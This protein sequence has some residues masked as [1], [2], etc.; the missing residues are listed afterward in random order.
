MRNKNL[1]FLSHGLL[2]LYELTLQIIIQHT[3]GDKMLTIAGDGLDNDHSFCVNS[4]RA[5]GSPL[6]TNQF[7]ERQN[8]FQ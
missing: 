8:N 2:C 4:D 3:L 5:R 7:P 1:D 6:R